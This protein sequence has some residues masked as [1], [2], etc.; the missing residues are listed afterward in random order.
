[1][2]AGHPFCVVSILQSHLD[3]HLG[4]TLATEGLAT[5]KGLALDG[6]KEVADGCQ[7]KEDSCG[8]QGR[9]SLQ[10]TEEQDNGHDAVGSRT[11]PVGGDLANGIIELGGGGADSEQQRHL[12]E[13]DEAAKGNSQRGKDNHDCGQGD[14]A[15]N[16]SRPAEDH[17]E[18]AQPVAQMLE[19][20]F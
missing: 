12:D 19:L 10:Q 18:N 11:R 9:G 3:N 17:A 20:C 5:D 7:S 1:M 2:S 15:G 6:G 8:N 16:T 13:Q 14:D 4:D